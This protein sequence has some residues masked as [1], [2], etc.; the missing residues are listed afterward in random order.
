MRG[1]LSIDVDISDL[2][3]NQCHLP[4]P[5]APSRTNQ[6]SNHEE[7]FNEI[8]VF[9]NSHKCHED[10]MQVLHYYSWMELTFSRINIS[11]TV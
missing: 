10:S 11:P 6:L 3:I 5:R 9:H 7:V 1:F 8:D 2:H 4:I